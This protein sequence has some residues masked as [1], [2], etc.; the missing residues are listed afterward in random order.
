MSIPVTASRSLLVC[1]E[2]MVLTGIQFHEQRNMFEVLT[3]NS[4]VH[5]TNITL[6]NVY[7]AAKEACEFQFLSINSLISKVFCE[8]CQYV[9]STIL[10]NPLKLKIKRVSLLFKLA[11]GTL[12][13]PVIFTEDTFIH[14]SIYPKSASR[15]LQVVI[16]EEMKHILLLAAASFVFIVFAPVIF[17]VWLHKWT[18]HRFSI[19]TS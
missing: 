14:F 4:T 2:G 1:S 9:A 13:Q 19:M 10:E 3:F 15:I 11:N 18:S 17:F 6:Q 7:G 8:N 5:Q 12:S 16:T